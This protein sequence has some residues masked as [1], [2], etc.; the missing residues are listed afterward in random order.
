[1]IDFGKTT[2]IP[3]GVTIDHSSEWERGNHEDGYLTG[4]ASL[5]SLLEET[6]Q[7]LVASPVSES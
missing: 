2:P 3:D 4:V 7:D 5:I 6:L 1:M